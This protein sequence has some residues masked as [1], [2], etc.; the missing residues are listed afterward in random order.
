[1]SRIVVTNSVTLDGVMQAPGRANEDRRDGFDLGGWAQPYADSVMGSV[2]AAGIGDADALLFGRKT[3]ADFA[4]IWPAMTLDNPY[5]EVINN[6]PKYVTSK[7]LPGPLA[8]NNSILLNGEATTTVAEL[9]ERPGKDIVI[10]G[11]GE[12]VR[13]LMR[14]GLIDQYTLLIHPLVLGTGRRLFPD[15]GPSA[16]LDLVDSRTTST[17]VIIAT[18]RPAAPVPPAPPVP[19][20]G[21]A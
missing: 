4:S 8:W 19:L 20:P 9:R 1:M 12:L 16:S 18:Y 3:Y 10:L 6:I 11:S 5:T 21:L 17:G 13:A 2:M 15:G 7:T 14:W